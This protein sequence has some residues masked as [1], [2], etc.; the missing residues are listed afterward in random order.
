MSDNQNIAYVAVAALFISLGCSP[1][2]VG[3]AWTH[4]QMQELPRDPQ[5]AADQ[6]KKVLIDL[7]LI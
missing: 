6:A 5:E 3:I 2:S 4:L 1:D 7:H